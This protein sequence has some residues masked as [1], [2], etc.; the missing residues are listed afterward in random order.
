MSRWLRGESGVIQGDGGSYAEGVEAWLL[1]A[2]V[3]ED[4]FFCA[5]H[6]K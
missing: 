3:G 1:D 2:T 4:C 5:A 6:W